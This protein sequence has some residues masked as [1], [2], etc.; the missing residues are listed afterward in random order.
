VSEV[1]TI[2]QFN[3]IMQAVIHTADWTINAEYRSFEG[4][5]ALE[6]LKRYVTRY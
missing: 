3:D 4:A 1:F 5:V 6:K 2:Y